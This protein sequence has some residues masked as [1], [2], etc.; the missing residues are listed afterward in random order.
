LAETVSKNGP[1]FYGT[2]YLYAGANFA[3]ALWATFTI[4]DNRGLS[5]VK[6]E[7]NYESQNKA[8]TANANENAN[9]EEEPQL[10]SLIENKV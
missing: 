6:V 1:Q 2:F 10:Q 8:K 9:D 7:E 4:P 3:A 5:L